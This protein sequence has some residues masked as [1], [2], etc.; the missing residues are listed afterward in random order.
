MERYYF[1]DFRQT[2]SVQ[3]LDVINGAGGGCFP[4]GTFV[5]TRYGKKPIENI[6]QGE[7]VIAYDRF[8]EIEFGYVAETHKHE[9][10]AITGQLY[11]VFSNGTS[12][13][14]KGITSN[15]AVF[16][17][18]T[19]EHKQI[20]EFI[21]GDY[22]TALDGQLVEITE[23]QIV[24][25]TAPVYNLTVV[26]QHTFLVETEDSNFVRVHNGGGGKSSAGAARAASEAANTLQTITTAKILEIISHGEIDGIV[27]GAKGVTFNNTAL[28]DS[29]GNWNFQNVTFAERKGTVSQ[30]YVPGFSEVEAEYTDIPGT[31]LTNALPFVKDILASDAD[32]VRVTIRVMEGLWQQNTSNGDLN[33]Y[34]VSYTISTKLASESTWNVIVTQTINDKTTSPAEIAHR[35]EKPAGSGNWGVKI[36]RTSADDT[37]AAT[38]SKIAVQRITKIIEQTL[39]YAKI[40]YA[41]LIVPAPSVGNNIP[42][43]GYLVKGIK[44]LIPSNYDPVLKTYSG[45]WWDGSFVT[46]WTDNTA[47]ILYDLIL[48]AEY[49][50]PS[51]LGFP[52]DVDKWEFFRCALYNDCV[53][54]NSGTDT[55]A[56]S[57]I[58]DGNG[59]TEV[60]FTCN[61]VI[62][63]QQDA[64]QLLQAVAS[65][66]HAI[67]YM[68]G[69]SISLIQDRP[70]TSRKIIN[71]SNVINGSFTYS[72]TELTTRNTAVNVT[73]N[74]PD[75]R[76]LPK[77][78][79]Q[80]DTTAINTYGYVVKDLMAYGCTRESQARREALYAIYTEQNQTDL[81]SFGM[82][83]NIVDIGIGDVVT[84][85]DNDIAADVNEYLSGRVISVTGAEIVL[86]RTVTLITGHTYHF[87]LTNLT[88]TDIIDLVITN[89]AGAHS[90]ITVNSAPPAGDYANKEFFCFS[91]G[92]VEP[93][94]VI[95]SGI[96]ESDEKIYNISGIQ[97]SS[98]KYAYVDSNVVVPATSYSQL[99]STVLPQVSAITF[100]EVFFND[101]LTQ[102]AYLDV[103]WS[104]DTANTIK[105]GVAFR[106]RWRRDNDNYTTVNEITVKSFRIINAV[107]GNY[108]IIIEAY[109]LQGKFSLPALG[110]YAYR[111]SAVASVLNPPQNFYVKGTTGVEFSEIHVAV[112]WTYDTLNDA[113]SDRLLDYLLEIVSTDGTTVLR[114]LTIPYDI[115]SK[116]GTFDYLLPENITDYG[117]ASRNVRMRL[118]SR[119]TT[120]RIS[121]AV[122]KT[123]TNSVPA[124]PVFTVLSGMNSV[125]LKITPPNTQDVLGYLVY[126]RA[127][128]ISAWTPIDADIVYD[129]PDTYITIGTSVSGNY[130]Y[131]V[132]AYDSF[133][134]TGL[135]I[136]TMQ[137]SAT[138]SASVDKFAYSGMVFT[139]NSPIANSVA[140]NAFG[141]SV[142]G[143]AVAYVTA[144][145]AAWT[146]GTLYLCFDKDTTS[147]VTTTDITV[148]V[149]KSQI[150]AAYQGGTNL[151]GGDGSAFINGSQVIAQSIGASQ[152]VAN[153]AIITQTAQIAAAL[154]NETHIGT[155]AIN[156]AAIKDFIQSANWSPGTG[157]VYAGW[158]V[159]KTGNITSYGN[160]DIRD[161]LGNAVITTGPTAGVEWGKVVNKSEDNL[162][163]NPDFL[164]AIDNTSTCPGWSLS[165]SGTP[166]GARYITGNGPNWN[167]YQY[168]LDGNADSADDYIQAVSDSIFVDITK[169]YCASAYFK[170]I[171]GNPHVTLMANCY[172]VS[173]T[174]LGSVIFSGM[175]GYNLTDT[176]FTQHYG[177]CG[178]DGTAF[179]ANTAYIRLAIY[180]AYG[181]VGQAL[182]TRV[183][184]NVGK[185]PTN[186]VNPYNKQTVNNINQIT[187]ANAS[188]FI[189]NA[190][191]ARA[192]IGALSVQTAD[193]VDANI[194]TL[195]IAGRAVTNPL[196]ALTDA[197]ISVGYTA[198]EPTQEVQSITM[199]D[200]FGQLVSVVFSARANSFTIG[201]SLYRNGTLLR[202]IYGA[203][204]QIFTM[205][206]LD[207]PPGGNV[208][209]TVKARTAILG[210]TGSVSERYLGLTEN[211]R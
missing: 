147:V 102:N 140:W 37:S 70:R 62:N 90:T 99:I 34:T 197:A 33:G 143:G 47:W 79:T 195:K 136:A 209:Y 155:A 103:T 153:T 184:L 106:V 83:L 117:T 26:P 142:N 126:R 113:K 19:N 167:P 115:T 196:S 105:G 129:G 92:F 8:G 175:N 82:G 183:L 38:K 101:G 186:N 206:Y 179:L 156:N 76:Y 120:G 10:T 29:S 65:N 116:G 162:I 59:G 178:P 132:A 110:T 17:H 31:E 139:P 168:V 134:K 193:I 6:N 11:F 87:G 211:K 131:R 187:S 15:H 72:S 98:A 171:S 166:A 49:G 198:G 30:T 12:L 159:D 170:K 192:Q 80:E 202:T 109:N 13:F 14:P 39:S 188:T 151:T 149:Q 88:N 77:T 145:N 210:Q 150:L 68:N 78:I 165:V 138:L 74:D 122:D 112:T 53:T 181:S 16:D 191:I 174:Y 89:A 137:T 97:Y 52:L 61:L 185:T 176:A 5:R 94:Q 24:D 108:D 207:T 44:C 160:L 180:T 205:H 96:T 84:I 194:T 173:N 123:F 146:V 118:Y 111:L 199:P 169:N 189:A 95:I 91:S 172:N 127:H 23:L 144:S 104:W 57:L 66:M 36:T 69:S 86:D 9:V 164:N 20:S 18:I 73:F 2:E 46:A 63:T 40:A 128:S 93:L 4:A 56:Q 130:D 107:P 204:D 7:I 27:G 163:A 100:N 55:Y 51:F 125:F 154:I 190:A 201:F 161:A 85:M 67:V 135:N 60:R 158:K 71:N 43:R 157:G 48:N 208:T 22:V 45:G 21:I 148:A 54:Y 75:D 124:A 133:G 81:V 177:V 114:S 28:Q 41:A 58:S 203:A 64:W 121:V 1:E 35:I 182:A 3:E 152:L 119:D 32:A 42:V 141:V 25:I 200:A 50:L